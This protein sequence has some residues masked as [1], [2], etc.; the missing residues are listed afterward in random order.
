MSSKRKTRSDTKKDSEKDTEISV[1][2]GNI[3]NFREGYKRVMTNYY[4]SEILKL[5]NKIASI[6]SAMEKERKRVKSED[7]SHS[8][9][10]MKS[11][12]QGVIGA[13]YLDTKKIEEKAISAI[14]K[15]ESTF[16][17]YGNF[18]HLRQE[19]EDAGWTMG[20]RIDIWHDECPCIE[21]SYHEFAL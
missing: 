9:S 5:Q 11:Y 16:R 17:I 3:D 8:E 18:E 12:K 19:I 2:S 1:T 14:Q 20:K 6:D 13:C 15:G 10:L 4:N 21:D 7:N